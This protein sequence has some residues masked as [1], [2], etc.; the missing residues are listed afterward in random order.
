MLRV[1]EA[2]NIATEETSAAN[3]FEPQDGEGYDPDAL[4]WDDESRSSGSAHIRIQTT[5]VSITILA[6]TA[7]YVGIHFAEMQRGASGSLWLSWIAEWMIPS[8]LLVVIWHLAVRNGTGEQTRFANA[9]ALLSRESALLET[10][11]GT[12]NRELS[13]ARDFIASQSRDLESLGRVAAE[14][15][16]GSAQSLHELIEHNSAQVERIGQVGDTAIANMERLRDQ[17]PVL[18]NSARDMTNQIGNA[19]N[20]AQEQLRQLVAGFEQLDQFG[21]AG[22]RHVEMISARM[23]ETLELFDRHAGELGGMASD[24]FTMLQRSSEEFRNLLKVQD[25]EAISTF[26]QRAD[27]L[28]EFL[29]RRNNHLVNIEDRASTGMRERLQSMVSQSD[30]LLGQ[31]VE[32]R[33]EASEGVNSAIAALEERLAEAIRKVAGIDELAMSNARARMA[34]LA[35]EAGRIEATIGEHSASFEADLQ[36]RS[37]GL[38]E[39]EIAALAAL[40]TRMSA[41]D[42]Q[43]QTRDDSHLAYIESLTARGEMLSERLS[44]F[45]ADMGRLT[46]QAAQAHE[47]IGLTADLLADRLAQSREILA[48]SGQTLAGLTAA[49][50]GLLDVIRSGTRLADGELADAVG[51]AEARLGLFHSNA[52]SLREVMEGAELRGAALAEHVENAREHGASTLGLLEQ[53]ET[54]L[55]ELAERSAAVTGQTRDELQAAFDMLT[56]STANVLRNLREGQTEAIREIAEQIAEKSNSAI[57]VALRDQAATTIAEIESSARAAGVAGRETTAQLRDQLEKVNELAGNLEQ[58][59]AA[60]RERSEEQMGDDFVRRMALITESLNSGAIDIAKAFDN[61]VA[62]TQWSNYLRG[63]R[64]IFTRRAVRLLDKSQAR[65]VFEFYEADGDFRET[66]NRY[67]HDFEAMLRSVLS[68]RDGNALAVTLLSSDVGKLYVCL[69]QSI[70]RLRG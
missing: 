49:G 21:N 2:D 60:A 11:L 42:Q 3:E 20:V 55:S 39:R 22:E 58:R 70:D 25:E 18:A 31:M 48:E 7:A 59:V 65:A 30:Q 12:V 67:I 36:R 33:N 6:W 26:R 68:T 54:Q 37:S 40:E 44:A 27:G 69:A 32:R 53:L 28:T 14:R 52:E 13:L 64:G 9:A 47:G 63:D 51:R 43:V 16:N 29:E 38:H 46:D 1:G 45:D 35:E 41:F 62:D 56:M 66:V 61:D 4:I 8:L 57:A 10:R 15:L 24:Q 17:M 34:A 50:G 23:S 5:L 19:G